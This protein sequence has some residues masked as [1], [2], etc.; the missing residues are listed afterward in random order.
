MAGGG[1]GGT[2][3]VGALGALAGLGV[4]TEDRLRVP[5]EPRLR[6]GASRGLLRGRHPEARITGRGAVV[7]GD[8]VV[9]LLAD[10]ARRSRRDAGGL[11]GWGPSRGAWASTAGR[12]RPAAP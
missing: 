10:P 12:L 6:R 2:T 3:R 1:G 5:G 9:L 7:T 11:P 4:S 8:G